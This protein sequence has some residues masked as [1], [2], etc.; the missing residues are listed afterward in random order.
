LLSKD[1]KPFSILG[2]NRTDI[3]TIQVRIPLEPNIPVIYQSAG[4]FIE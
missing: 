4:S 1:D 2:Q 3:S